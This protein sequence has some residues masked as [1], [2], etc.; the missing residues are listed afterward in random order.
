MNASPGTTRLLGLGLPAL[1]L[2][3]VGVIAFRDFVFGP[4][5]LLYKDIGSDSLNY[6]YPYLLLFS[7]Y[8][9]TEGLPLWSFR[10]GFGQTLFPE[11]GV[12]VFNPAAWF[13]RAWIAPLLVW[14]HLALV[15]VA[16]LLFHRFLL[17][18]GLSLA[19]SLLGALLLTFSA[20]MTMGSCWTVCAG[21]VVCVAFALFALETALVRG[22][23][24]YLPFSVAL[25]PLLTA[26][27]LYLCAVLMTGYLLARLATQPR[28][29][30]PSAWHRC[31]QLG[32]IALLGAG[33]TAV[34]WVDSL[35]QIRNSPRG[36]G[37][38]S[39][40][41]D[42]SSLGLFHFESPLHYFTIILR[43]FANDLTGAGNAYRG[44]ANYLEAALPYCGLLSLLL[45][46]QIFVRAN[47]RLRVVAGVFL[48][49]VVFAHAFPWFRNLFYL[50][51]GDYYRAFSLFSAV[52]MIILAV[53][54]FSRYV[55]H[56]LLNVWL[57]AGTLAALLCL[58]YLPLPELQRLA[59]RGLQQTAALLLFSY[60]VLLSLG[61][62]FRREALAAW[63]LIGLAAA[64]L[65]SFSH[66]TASRDRAVVTKDEARQRI[67]F[68]DYTLE[69]LRVLKA[70]DP[71]F[72]RVTKL[73]S[74]SGAEHANLNDSFAFDYYGTTAYT[75]FLHLNYVKFLIGLNAIVPNPTELDTRWCFGVVGRPLLGAFAC[76][77]YLLTQGPLP[78]ETR[79]GY[80]EA[81]RAEDVHIYRN[82]SFLPFGLF[83]ENI[84]TES[85]FNQFSAAG[86]D[87][88]LFQWAVLADGLFAAEFPGRILPDLGELIQNTETRATPELAAKRRERSLTVKSFTQ[89][90]I[91]G[92]IRNEKDGYL[93]F[94]MP[95]ESGWRAYVNG[96]RA[97]TVRVDFGLLGLRLPPGD[98]RI[99][100]R[101]L[102]PS[103]FTGGTLSLIAV[104]VLAFARWRW[105]RISSVPSSQGQSPTRISE[106]PK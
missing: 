51:Q 80:E 11:I 58:L 42:L 50:F 12:L 78:P 97:P 88:L 64:E 105:P 89:N 83:F 99:A 49:A 43:S 61:Q 47:A 8:I 3:L 95:F 44:S 71:A 101:Y 28:G 39:Y 62:I 14:Q 36:S 29:D 10:V 32:S 75:S 15:L 57:L 82:S 72:Y 53:T 60:A 31:Y 76:E 1:V 98:H 46:P 16:G 33:L 9:R 67:G 106:S 20:Y 96:A 27:H 65:A 52:G 54:V 73:Y 100:L 90:R 17:L 45:L 24:F 30:L 21:E 41:H 18:R 66:L 94:Q 5:L 48:A 86:K 93:V 4:S 38:A 79:A 40:A 7:D 2:L 68:N 70:S 35:I 103:L 87:V 59:D 81:G 91:E 104:L 85:L 56:R 25:F 6:Y 23:W 92:S 74:S 34:V 37:L 102:P 26:F 22:R 69:A 13:P 63:L 55:T 84:L 19:A 77:K